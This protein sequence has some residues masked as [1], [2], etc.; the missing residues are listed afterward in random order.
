M[1]YEADQHGYTIFKELA[2]RGITNA[3]V[4]ALMIGKE[5]VLDSHCFCM[6]RTKRYGWV[7]LDGA[8]EGPRWLTRKGP[9]YQRPNSQK[10]H[11]NLHGIQVVTMVEDTPMDFEKVKES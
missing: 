8:K 1:L 5:L 9:K 2:S 7:V 3:L 4:Y 11:A 10:F 6:K